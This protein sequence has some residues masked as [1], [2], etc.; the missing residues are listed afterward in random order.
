MA[1]RTG[2][3]LLDEVVQAQQRGQARGITSICSAHPQ[4][5]GVAMRHARRSGAPLLIESTCNQVNQYGGYTGMTPAGFSSFLQ[6]IAA[7]EGLEP[8]QLLVGGDHLGPGPWQDEPAEAAMQKASRLVA[9]CVLAGYTKLHLDASMRLGDDSP[10]QPLDPELSARRSAQLAQVAEEAAR[11]RGDGGESLRYVIGSE[12]PPPGGIQAGQK[13]VAVTATDSAAETVEVTRLAFTQ[14]GQ[15]G[16]WE[17]VMALVVEAGVEYGEQGV[18]AYDPGRAAELVGWIDGQDLVYEAHSTDYQTPEALSQMVADHFAILKVGPALTFAFREAVFALEEME[19]EL[20]EESGKRSWLRQALEQAMLRDPVHW[21]RYASGDEVQRHLARLYGL[22]DRARYYWPEPEV[23]AALGRLLRNLE[24]TELP[25]G[26]VSQYLPEQ[27]KRVL[28]GELEATPQA[29]IT[30]K[31]VA[32]LE[33]YSN[34]CG[35]GIG[36]RG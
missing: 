10:D 14:L 24:G 23:Q 36:T 8:G 29:L 7:R 20:L 22:S 21:E 30:D 5:L 25:L 27:A 18:Y 2:S 28:I 13:Q 19:A 1:S 15:P 9:E 33:G 4:V 11:Q 17:R 31:I 35:E 32:V 26:L 34:A 12:V 3:M 6:E 16:A